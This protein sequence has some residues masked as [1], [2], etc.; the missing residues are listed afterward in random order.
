M[1][2]IP[3]TIAKAVSES[4]L[5]LFNESDRFHDWDS[6]EITA[7]RD[8]ITKLQKVDAQAAFKNFGSVAA[9]CG[10]KEDLR[11]FFRKSCLLP[12]RRSNEFSFWLNFA[13][14]GEYAEAR[15]IGSKLLQPK[16]GFFP[17][18]WEKAVARG[19][20]REVV[21]LWPVAKRTFLDLDDK[22]LDPVR[23]IDEVLRTWGIT[24]ADLIAILEILGAVQQSHRIMFSGARPLNFDVMEGDPDGP[25]YVYATMFIDAP[26]EEVQIM[27]R[28]V[29][30]AVAEKL[31][32]FPSGLVMAFRKARARERLLPIAA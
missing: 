3:E 13:N 32:A 25:A 17:R 26:I 30:N 20:I 29:A 24:D 16:L 11:Q 8:E 19:Q 4:I 12:D 10:R 5:A 22:D 9:L 7:I 28:K 15:E 18:L 27:N 31:G 23:K 2:P 21:D 1:T 6:P 14:A